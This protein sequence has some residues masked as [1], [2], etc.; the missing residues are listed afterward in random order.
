MGYS[1][2]LVIMM[3]GIFIGIGKEVMV[4]NDTSAIRVMY[5]MII[6]ILI[7]ILLI[8]MNIVKAV[9]H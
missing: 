8:V 9:M 4:D 3:L 6:M 2:I 1:D 7:V 5:L